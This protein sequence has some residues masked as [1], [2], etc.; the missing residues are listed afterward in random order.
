MTLEL[1]LII[2]ATIPLIVIPL[3]LL[4]GGIFKRRGTKLKARLQNG[5]TYDRFGG[6]V[7]I[8][9]GKKVKKLRVQDPEQSTV[10]W[11]DTT[12]N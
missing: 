6:N 2:A 9:S 8:N 12:T 4:L 10:Q 3:V 7:A 5:K 11:T 1:I